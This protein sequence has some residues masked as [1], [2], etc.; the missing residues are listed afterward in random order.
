MI[1]MTKSSI[2]SPVTLSPSRSQSYEPVG[3]CPAGRQTAAMLLRLVD[4]LVAS[5]KFLFTVRYCR[6]AALPRTGISDSCALRVGDSTDTAEPV[7][8]HERSDALRADYQSRRQHRCV[9]QRLIR[10][11]HHRRTLVGILTGRTVQDDLI[12]RFDLRARSMAGRIK[13]MP[14][15]AGAGYRHFRGS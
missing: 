9:G 11:A 13:R 15:G 8:W 10:Y 2:P 1:N 6:F 5:R 4:L 3:A 14:Q 12:N 7:H